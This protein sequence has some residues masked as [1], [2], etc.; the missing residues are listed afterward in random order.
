MQN[1]KL[2]I[3]LGFFKYMKLK[4]YLIEEL[5]N[6]SEFIRGNGFLKKFLDKRVH[7]F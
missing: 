4:S 1:L 6:S 7:L 2:A 5:F 3:L